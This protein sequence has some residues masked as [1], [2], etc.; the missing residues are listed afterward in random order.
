VEVWAVFCV[1]NYVLVHLVG[2]DNEIWEFRNDLTDSLH[3]TERKDLPRR[4]VR[5]VDD[6][7]LRFF[8]DRRLE[9]VPVNH[10]AI[11]RVVAI[12]REQRAENWLPS[13][14]F[15]L[16][17]VNVES[18]LRRAKVEVSS[19]SPTVANSRT[20]LRYAFF[21]LGSLTS[22]KTTSSPGFIKPCIVKYST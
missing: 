1:E 12:L 22:N 17:G 19:G 4:I 10:E 14:Q 6:Q 16:L 5:S 7:S 8:R 13:S 18:W 2:D 21:Q 20:S 9:L 15:D 11:V 3:L